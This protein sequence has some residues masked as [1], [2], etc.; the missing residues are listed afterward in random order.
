VLLLIEDYKCA[1]SRVALEEDTMIVTAYHVRWQAP[2]L[3]IYKTNWDATIDK[4]TKRIG[5]KIIARNSHGRVL[6]AHSFTLSIHADPSVAEAWAFTLLCLAKTQ[7]C[8]TS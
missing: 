2:P 6:V 3:G 4:R 1:N 8:L 5:I 7:V